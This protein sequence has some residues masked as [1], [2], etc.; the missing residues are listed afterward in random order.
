MDSRGYKVIGHIWNNT[1][2]NLPT[3]ISSVSSINIITFILN[4]RI[5]L[6]VLSSSQQRFSQK[7][8]LRVCKWN[9]R[10]HKMSLLMKIPMKM[11]EFGW[12]KGVQLAQLPMQNTVA[13]VAG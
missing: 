2:A 8:Q 11:K 1:I 10:V 6:D 5:Y 3:D 13:W 7:L 9:F 12:F 4:S